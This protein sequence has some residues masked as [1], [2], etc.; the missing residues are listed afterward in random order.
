MKLI[1]KYHSVA[2]FVIYTIV[3][4][5]KQISFIDGFVI[6]FLAAYVGLSFYL[7]HSK[8]PDIRADVEAKLAF[9]DLQIKQ[10]IQGASHKNDSDI[11]K[12][13]NDLK[14]MRSKVAAIGS[15]K[16]VGLSQTSI[17]F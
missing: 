4:N 13:E 11:R 9:M 17:K 6:S 10:A 16:S 1:S 3:L 2:L 14:D 12:M 5:F 15:L 7:D 8:Q